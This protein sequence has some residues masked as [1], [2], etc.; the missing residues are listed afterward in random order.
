[1]D[2]KPFTAIVISTFKSDSVYDTFVEKIKDFN[3]DKLINHLKAN[4]QISRSLNRIHEDEL[5]RN[6]TVW[7]YTNKKYWEECQRLWRKFTGI[8]SNY[9]VKRSSF[10]G[11]E[12]FS[13]K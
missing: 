11:E 6:V 13:W 1:M 9:I 2:D 7:K 12:I 3:S 4:G 8:G 10:I 5:I